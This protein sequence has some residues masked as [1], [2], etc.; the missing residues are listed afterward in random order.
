VGWLRRGGTCVTF[1]AFEG[2]L[3]TFVLGFESIGV[4][5]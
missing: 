1:C 2:T 3:L 4:V 5:L